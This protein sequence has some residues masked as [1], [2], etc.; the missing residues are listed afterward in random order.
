MDPL[1]AIKLLEFEVS[2]LPEESPVPPLLLTLPLWPLLESCIKFYCFFSL[3]LRA[4]SRESY[5]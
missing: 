5:S 4:Y 3:I 2:P 1:G